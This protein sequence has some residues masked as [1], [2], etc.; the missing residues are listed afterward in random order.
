M[1][2]FTSHLQALPNASVDPIVHS[3]TC[4]PFDQIL[5]TNASQQF[6]VRSDADSSS[7]PPGINLEDPPNPP[8]T[9]T[10]HSKWTPKAPS[11]SSANP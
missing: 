6:C 10:S 11:P 5:Q 3:P 9:S 4:A 7:H 8:A 1:N 2:A